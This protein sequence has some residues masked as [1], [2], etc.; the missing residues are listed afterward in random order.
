[1]SRT[2]AT[3]VM[4]STPEIRLQPKTKKSQ[5]LRIHGTS[6]TYP[7]NFGSLALSGET[8]SSRSTRFVV[9]GRG[10]AF[11]SSYPKDF[12]RFSLPSLL[13]TC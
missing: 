5:N 4:L 9:D 12:V 6:Y 3:I 1:M 8:F 10:A 2:K 11:S 7:A 13:F